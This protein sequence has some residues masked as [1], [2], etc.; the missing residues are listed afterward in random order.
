MTSPLLE[1][2]GYLVPAEVLAGT[3]VAPAGT[4]IYA[5]KL[6]LQLK[7]DTRVAQARP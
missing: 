3:Y 2:F 1:D 4:D 5:K 7:M 6:L